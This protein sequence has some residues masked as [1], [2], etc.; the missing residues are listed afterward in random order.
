MSGYQIA[1]TDGFQRAR[2]QLDANMQKAVNEAVSKVQ[3]GHGATHPHKLEGTAF[4]AFGVNRN[5]FRV[6]C[7]REGQTLLLLHVGPHDAAYD[8]AERHRVAQVGEVVRVRRMVIE[9]DTPAGL[10]PAEP[11][12]PGPL[13][14]VRDRVFARFK[15]GPH[16]AVGF[17]AIPDSEALFEVAEHL[18]PPLGEAL[19]ALS[20]DPDDVDAAYARFVG[21]QARPEAPTLAEAIHAPVNSATVWVPPPGEEALAA[22]L[23]GELPAWRVFLHPSQRRLVTHRGKGALKVTGGPGT[24][25]TVVALH[26]ARWLA[27]ERFADDPRPVLITTFNAT[28]ARQLGEP[29]AQLTAETPALADRVA[30]VSLV[31]VA[32]QVLRAVGQ[33]ATLLVG[34][35]VEAAWR[36]ALVHDTEGLGRA[37]YDAERSQ[38]IARAGAWTATQYLKARRP[39]RPRTDRPGRKRIWAV[40]D[41][42]EQALL[43]AGGGDGIALAH[44]AAAAVLAHGVRP[45]SAV[46]CDEAQDAGA[47]ELRLLAALS[48]GEDGGIDP[49]RL[50]LCGDGNQRL[51]AQPVTFASC[52]IEIRG[53]S[54]RLRLN[55]RTTEGIRAAAVRHVQGLPIDPVDA[56]DHAD[57]P[58]RDPL[59][60]YRSVRRGEAPVSR[61][62]DDA[63]GEADWIAELASDAADPLLVLAPTHRWLDGLAERLRARGLPVHTLTRQTVSLA[64]TGITLCTLHRAKGLEAPR[65]VLAGLGA[66][67]PRW[68]ARV[69]IPKD[70]WARQQR[71]LLYVGMTRARD[72]CGLSTVGGAPQDADAE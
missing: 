10:A 40:I 68:T 6:I 39:G 45:W 9:T 49:D 62:F 15:V 16:G 22:A 29:L 55:Y 35:A 38:V 64:P 52:G 44:R 48:R 27:T 17:R 69:A 24:G 4:V 32:Q 43:S 31:A 70:Q 66:G 33:P 47:D 50:F 60:G 30:V 1:L 2:N 37:F 46:V 5:A 42:F 67:E 54:K 61:R 21:A 11:D 63:D 65:V 13:H 58:P 7:A 18:D 12:V 23:E 36:E 71:C 14:T 59:T 28:L 20:D 51:Y 56:D 8:W 19:L 72:W 3:S 26:R 34:E 57:G 25:K 41:A 53:R